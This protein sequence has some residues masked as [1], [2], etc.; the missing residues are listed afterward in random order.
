[1]AKRALTDRSLKALKPAP[2]G[3]RYDRMDAIV[4]GLAVRVTEKGT[5]SFVL[6]ARFP[7]SQ[8]PTDALSASTAN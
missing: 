6:V 2:R 4:P 7:G 5:K 8:N 3:K 1:M